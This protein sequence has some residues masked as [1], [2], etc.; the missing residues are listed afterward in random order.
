MFELELIS[1]LNNY[2]KADTY[3]KKR[4][5][6]SITNLISQNKDKLE[7][8]ASENELDTESKD[9]LERIY[10]E[11]ESQEKKNFDENSSDFE[12]IKTA[13]EKWLAYY[14]TN[15][16][17]PEENC[18]K[19]IIDLINFYVPNRFEILKEALNIN[20]NESYEVFKNMINNYIRKYFATKIQ[21]YYENGKFTTLN[22]FQKRKKR[23]ELLKIMDELGEYKF[24]K[25]KIEDVIK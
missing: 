19:I 21:N 22:F 1:L 2:K 20:D 8:F 16:N 4:I 5:S 11:I 15:N 25:Q 9:L 14:E 7:K 24:N 3:E 23:K 6:E 10:K 13:Y 18:E 12:V 17:I